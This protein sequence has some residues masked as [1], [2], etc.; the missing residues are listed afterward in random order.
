MGFIGAPVSTNTLNV[1]PSRWDFHNTK[2]AFLHGGLGGLRPLG[3]V[4]LAPERFRLVFMSQQPGPGS[5]R[6][7]P[8]PATPRWPACCPLRA[9]PFRRVLPTSAPPSSGAS[10]GG[11]PLGSAQ[12]GQRPAAAPR[13][14]VRAVL[15]FGRCEGPT[16][17]SVPAFGSLR[18]RPQCPHFRNPGF[19]CGSRVRHGGTGCVTPAVPLVPLS[20]SVI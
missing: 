7:P 1:I 11:G 17:V 8:L 9:R 5:S 10:A 18:D 20:L 12:A 16:G 15:A 3:V 4:R 2:S 19:L 13:A 6:A 14:A